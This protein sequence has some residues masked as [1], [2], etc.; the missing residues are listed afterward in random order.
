MME[1]CPECGGEVIKDQC[2]YCG[3]YVYVC[4]DCCR[5]HSHTAVTTGVID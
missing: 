5:V 2:P 4:R 1:D 3:L